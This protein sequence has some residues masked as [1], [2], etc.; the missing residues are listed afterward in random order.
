MDIAFAFVTVRRHAKPATLP[1][2]FAISINQWT[3]AL[4]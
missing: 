2:S 3:H 4:V 1:Y